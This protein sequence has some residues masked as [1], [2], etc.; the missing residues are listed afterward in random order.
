[1]AASSPGWEWGPWLL[2]AVL[3]ARTAP[4]LRR[5]LAGADAEALRVLVVAT[6]AL[7]AMRWFNTAALQGVMLHFLGATIATLMF[8]AG[9]ACW[10]M[11]ASSLAGAL[12]G[13]AWHGW[14]MDFL[15]TGA[16]PV[17][18]SAAASRAARTWLPRNIFTYVMLNAFA[19][20]ALAMAASMLAKAAVVAWLGGRTLAAYL[21]ATPMLMFAEAFFAGTVMVLVVVYRPH[22]CRSF[23]DRDYLWP[24]RGM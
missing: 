13:A 2:A 12:M 8:G 11:A 6:L 14:A 3:L 7:A 9:A 10:V 1:M 15:A 5:H 4:A 17:A 18:V 23:D 21:A 19:G 22:W 20:G 24:Q 16:L